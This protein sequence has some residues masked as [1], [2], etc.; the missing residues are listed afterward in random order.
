VT[1]PTHDLLGVPI[2][3]VT[4]DEAIALVDRA[5]AARRPLQIGVVNAAKLVHMQRS[6]ELRADVL[7]SDLVLADGMAVVWAARLLGRPIPERVA[8]IDLMMQMLARGHARRYRVF[9][10][11]ATPAVLDAVVARIGSEFPGVVVAGS[12]HGYFT[13]DEE[14]QVAKAVADARPDILLIAMT[15]PK[16]E[17]FLARWSPQLDVPVCHGV[18]GSFDVF[19]GIVQRAPERWQRLGLEWLYRVKQEPRRLWKR[20]FT[21]NSAFVLMVMGA[22]VR[23]RLGRVARTRPAGT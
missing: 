11:G 15:S 21:T 5:I 12:Q 6:G 1:V 18:G 3:G 4:M 8:G 16:K 10:L 13:D 19:A 17:R 9:C 22:L 14:A 23:Q 20:Y 2:A 7:S